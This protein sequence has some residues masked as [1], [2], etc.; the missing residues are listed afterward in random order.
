MAYDETLAARYR[1][2]LEGLPEI[3]EQ[4]MMG[5]I[6]FMM[7]GNMIGGAHREKTGEGRFMFRVGKENQA[8]AL[9]RP[10]AR[11]MEFGGRRLGGMVFVDE[12][13]CSDTATLADWISLALSF[14]STLPPKAPKEPKS[15]KTAK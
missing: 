3:S 4:R 8:Q 11:P 2:A 10:G 5:G 15:K 13:V 6:C 12:E 9:A 14:V 1:D 7:S